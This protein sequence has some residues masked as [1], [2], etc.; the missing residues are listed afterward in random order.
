MAPE[1]LI[2]CCI[3]C[4]F[5]SQQNSIVNGYYDIFYI[6]HNNDNDGN[7]SIWTYLANRCNGI[8]PEGLLVG[9]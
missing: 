1:Y 6:S 3:Q 7:E 4:F 2:I 9:N 8:R 5:A